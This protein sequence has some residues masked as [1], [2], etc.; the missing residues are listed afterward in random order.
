M[1]KT[2]MRS[3]SALLML[4]VLLSA[5]LLPAMAMEPT[6]VPL[7]TDKTTYVEGEPIMVTAVGSGSDW[8]GIYLRDDTLKV[9]TSIRWYYVAMDGNTSGMTKNI[10]DAEYTNNRPDVWDLP[11]GEYSIYLLADGGYDVISR[12]DIT[13][14]PDPAESTPPSAPASVT[15]TRTAETAGLADGTLTITAGE[16]SLPVGYRAYWGNSEGPL[17]DYTAFAPISCEG[18]TTEYTMVPNTLI[19]TQAD[20]IYVYSVRKNAISETAATVLLPEGCND[21]SFGAPAY[22]LQVLSDIH[23][24]SSDSH[25]YNRHFAMALA[26]IQTVSPNS[27]GIFVN[28]DI[29]DHGREDEYQALNNLIANAGSNVPPVYCAIGNHDY[30]QGT[31]D[32]FVQ[33]TNPCVDKPYYDLWLNGAHFIF[34]GGE[35]AGLHADLSDTQLAWLEEKLAENRDPDRPIYLFLHQGLMDTVA[36]TFEYQGWHGVKQSEQLSRI[37]KN[38]PEIILFSGHSHWEMNSFQTMKMRDE[39]L[40]T[41]FNTAAGAYLWDDASTNIEGSQGYY[42]RVY[43]DKVLVLG[44]DFV[45]GKWVSAAQF[46]VDYSGLSGT[47]NPTSAGTEWTFELKN[48]PTYTI[49]IPAAVTLTREGTQVN[50]VAEN[51]ANL[52]GQRISVTIAGTDAYRNQMMLEGVNGK[53][54]RQSLRYCITTASG[55]RIE[56]FGNGKDILGKEL[57]SFTADGT[58]S[59]T[60]A[61]VITALEDNS[62]SYKGV[63][64]TGSMTYGIALVG[65]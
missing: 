44:R 25:L 58:V 38:Y 20:R 12:V 63:T 56:T 45:N 32:L 62:S 11:A 15:Y 7:Q 65:E 40:P 18:E 22:E 17:A 42:I 9:V 41:I 43:E 29:A 51:V 3:C 23:I 36:G 53:G 10:F 59:F 49:T 14:V 50:V 60:V 64:Y 19:P 6:E 35:K 48:D 52:D 24:N 39:N 30:G 54:I 46:V 1:K 26:D 8:V 13:I 55:E 61:P 34:L 47:E 31:S 2:L 28:G 21:Y 27:I 37:I 57:A 16:G 4:A 5:V 33:Y